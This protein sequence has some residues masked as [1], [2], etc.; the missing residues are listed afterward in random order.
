MVGFYRI[1]I[2]GFEVIAKAHYGAAPN[3]SRKKLWK[4]VSGPSALLL[5]LKETKVV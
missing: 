2:P 5:R 4:I 3:L 1:L